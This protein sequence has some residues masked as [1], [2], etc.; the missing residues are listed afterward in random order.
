MKSIRV[1]FEDGS[2]VT[3]HKVKKVLTIKEKKGVPIEY[4]NGFD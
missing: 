3:F 4:D 2:E 1:L